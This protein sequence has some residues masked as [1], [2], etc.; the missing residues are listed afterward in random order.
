MIRTV[1][2]GLKI[3]FIQAVM[4][5]FAFVQLCV[6]VARFLSM[7]WN[8]VVHICKYIFYIYDHFESNF[9]P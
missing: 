9:S 5:A 6:Q 7:D 2:L 1:K 8:I 3:F 4:C